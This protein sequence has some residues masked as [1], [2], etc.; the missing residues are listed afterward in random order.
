MIDEEKWGVACKASG[1]TNAK[2]VSGRLETEGIPTK[3]KYEAVG[4]IYAITI[5]GL[6]EVK[7]MV[8]ESLLDKAREVLSQ[9][10][11]DKD[12]DWE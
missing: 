2:I 5:N 10:Y 4:A 7:I 6:G 1:I 12:I 9:S 3:L 8:P 11:D